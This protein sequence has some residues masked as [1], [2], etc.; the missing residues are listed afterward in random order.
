MSKQASV[1]TE[2]KNFKAVNLGSWKELA[3]YELGQMKGKIFLKELLGLTGAEISFGVI[4]AGVAGPFFHDHKQNEEIYIVLHGQGQ[5]Q[6]GDTV[7]DLQEGTAVRVSP[8]IM[9]NLK[10]TGNTELAYMVIQTKADSLTQ[11]TMTDGVI[12]Q[13]TA[14]HWTK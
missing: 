2:A 5:M 1:I 11:W 13:D 4:P 7:F 9:R 12:S 10:N 14:A 6:L 3:G 8:G